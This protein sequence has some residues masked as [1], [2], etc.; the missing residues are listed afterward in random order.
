MKKNDEITKFK[1]KVE[2]F[3]SKLKVQPKQ[4]RIQKMSRKWAS[5]STKGWVSFA[6][7]LLRQPRS[8]QKHVIV[9]ELLHLQVPNHGKLFKALMK[10]FLGRSVC[11]QVGCKVEDSIIKKII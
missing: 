3:A 5:C 1:L 8:L 7:D 10:S 2:R 4:I 6:N 11:E 9:H